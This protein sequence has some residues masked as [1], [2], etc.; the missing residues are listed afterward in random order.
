MSLGDARYR[1]ANRARVDWDVDV[2]SCMVW[3]MVIE[4]PPPPQAATFVKGLVLEPQEVPETASQEP[5]FPFTQ[6]DLEA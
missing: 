2:Q 3:Y 6:V 1:G 4:L 5:R